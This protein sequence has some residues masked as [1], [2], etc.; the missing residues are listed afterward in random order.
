VVG[1][2]N[3]HRNQSHEIRVRELI[4]ESGWNTYISL[5]HEI[6]AQEGEYDRISTAAVNAYAGPGLQRYLKN[7]VARLRDAGLSVPV[8]AMQSTG[9]VSPVGQAE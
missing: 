4:E 5:G 6:L 9:G 7:L 1:F 2:L 3:A 8:M